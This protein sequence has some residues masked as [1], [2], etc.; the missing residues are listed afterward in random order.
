MVKLGFP[1]PVHKVKSV[2]CVSMETGT[3][4]AETLTITLNGFPLQE[5]DDGVTIYVAVPVPEG[6]VSN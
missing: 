1:V 5:P 3:Q 2:G 4:D 6:I